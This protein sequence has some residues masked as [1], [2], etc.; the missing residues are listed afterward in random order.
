MEQYILAIQIESWIHS[1]MEGNI[2]IK[3]NVK[4]TLS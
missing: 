1:N 4:E 3:W 2:N